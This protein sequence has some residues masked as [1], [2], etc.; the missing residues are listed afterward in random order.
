MKP[1]I[2]TLEDRRLFCTVIGGEVKELLP[3]VPAASQQQTQLTAPVSHGQD[4]IYG[5]TKM[6]NAQS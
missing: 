4:N 6:Q 2:E 3:I 1:L 5:A